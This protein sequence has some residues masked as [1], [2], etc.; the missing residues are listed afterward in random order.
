MARR[1]RRV[2]RPKAPAFG[3]ICQMLRAEFED[4]KTQPHPKR[5]IDLIRHLVHDYDDPDC[6]RKTYPGYFDEFAR[7]VKR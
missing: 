4:A 3:L 5:W 1:A 6:V 2:C 7:I